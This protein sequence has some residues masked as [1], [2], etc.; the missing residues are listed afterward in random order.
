ML[1][2]QGNS[3]FISAGWMEVHTV[4]AQSSHL[5]DIGI[6][7]AGIPANWKEVI[8]DCQAQLSIPSGIFLEAWAMCRVLYGRLFKVESIHVRRFKTC[9]LCKSLK[10]IKMLNHLE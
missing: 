3:T 5:R 10:I 7:G 9:F 1:E 8:N 4:T 6:Q 2:S